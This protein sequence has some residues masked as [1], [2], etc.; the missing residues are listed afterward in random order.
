[1]VDESA[2]AIDDLFPGTGVADFEHFPESVML[3]EVEHGRYGMPA[4]L[5]YSK[6]MPSGTVQCPP[7][8]KPCRVMTRTSTAG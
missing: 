2:P 7:Q 4:M 8:V 3:E 6:C 5:T 1:M